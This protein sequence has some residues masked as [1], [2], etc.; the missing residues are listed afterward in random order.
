MTSAG[1]SSLNST[2]KVTPVME[3]NEEDRLFESEIQL[4]PCAAKDVTEARD[5]GIV[6]ASGCTNLVHPRTNSDDSTILPSQDS[7]PTVG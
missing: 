2:L 3:G 4:A 1:A 5:E 7:R 6:R